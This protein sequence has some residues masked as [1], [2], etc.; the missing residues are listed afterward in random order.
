MTVHVGTNW[1]IRLNIPGSNASFCRLTVTI[2]YEQ[3]VIDG[4]RIV[5]SDCRV[6]VTVACPFVR[7]SVCHIDRQTADGL[8]LSA[9]AV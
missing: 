8:L 1:R 6:Y 5:C 4:A 9:G 3:V 2:C 7:P